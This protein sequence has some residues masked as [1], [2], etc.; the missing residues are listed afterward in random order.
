[1]RIA[2]VI[3]GGQTA[4][5]IVAAERLARSPGGVTIALDVPPDVPCARWSGTSDRAR[6]LRAIDVRRESW[7][8]DNGFTEERGDGGTDNQQRDTETR[9]RGTF[10]VPGRTRRGRVTTRRESKTQATVTPASFFFA[11][12]YAQSAV[13][14]GHARSLPASRNV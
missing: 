12:I 4:A 1:M 9:R 14:P 5:V 11:A 10:S 7:E 2:R 8:G 3:E 6:F 13:R